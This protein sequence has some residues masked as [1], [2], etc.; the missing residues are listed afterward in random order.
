MGQH[1]LGR[2]VHPLRDRHRPVIHAVNGVRPTQRVR[3]QII[4]RGE[5]KLRRRF[6]A[7][8]RRR[9]NNP[10]NTQESKQRLTQQG[11]T[12]RSSAN[13]TKPNQ[14]PTRYTLV[15]DTTILHIATAQAASSKSTHTC[16]TAVPSSHHACTAGWRGRFSRAASRFGAATPSPSFVSRL[17]SNLC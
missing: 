17:E 16:V 3:D 6:Q 11:T 15:K 8:T 13:L 9:Q 7:V 5:V 10:S 4:Q 12:A 14:T 1:P 2:L